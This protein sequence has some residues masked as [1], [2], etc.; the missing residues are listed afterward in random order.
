MHGNK[1]LA[2]AL[3][4]TMLL[5]GLWHGASWNFVVWGFLHGLLLLINRALSASNLITSAF[6][7]FPRTLTGIGWGTTQFSVF[8]TWLVFRIEDTTMLIRSMKSFVWFDSY[9]NVNELIET[10]PYIKLTTAL[11]VVAFLVLHGLSGYLGGGKYWL[12]RRHPVIWG[13]VCGISLGL[14]VLL[15][16]TEAIDFIYFRF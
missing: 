16:P 15:R 9:W 1:I 8:L 7:K 3:M 6:E 14:C 2:I 11:M 5:G 4:G 13:T 10:L 12:A